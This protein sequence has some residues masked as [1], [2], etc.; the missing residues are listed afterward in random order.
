[1]ELHKALRM[2]IETDGADII[3]DTRLVNI[4]SDFSSFDGFPASKYVL[5]AIIADGYAG[6]LLSEGKWDANAMALRQQF[7]SK[8]G[9][10]ND[11]VN[12]VFLSLAYGL[13][14]IDDLE[15]STQTEDGKKKETSITPQKQ[16]N[17]VKRKWSKDD[18]DNYLLSIIEWKTDFPFQYGITIDKV[19]FEIEGTAP[20]AL[21]FNAE[22]NGFMCK[23]NCDIWAVFY[24]KKNKIRKKS[25]LVFLNDNYV[26]FMV[27]SHYIEL[28]FPIKELSRIVIY[29]VDV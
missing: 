5:R 22:V 9:F 1:M 7:I 4:L 16:N 29:A 2:V 6:K 17:A 28:G 10:Q 26:D 15:F 20:Q 14:Y 23:S 12:T 8:T 25:N 27:I 18:Y 19:S 21:Y 3:K 24:D 13:S 11:L